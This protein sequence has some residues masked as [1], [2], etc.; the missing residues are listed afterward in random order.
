M[1]SEC[2]CRSCEMC[3]WVK[4][5][6][7]YIM[8]MHKEE[9]A[10]WVRK[11]VYKVYKPAT[12]KLNHAKWIC[13][14]VCHLFCPLIFVTQV[15]EAYA[16]SLNTSRHFHSSP[17]MFSTMEFDGVAL[18]VF[19]TSHTLHLCFGLHLLA[20]VSWSIFEFFLPPWTFHVHAHWTWLCTL[21]RQ[22]TRHL[23]NFPLL[24]PSC[25]NT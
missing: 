18:S 22:E 23:E 9:Y 12:Q 1:F 16:L 2:V 4:K 7:K 13:K 25:T 15:I 19:V 5:T 17:S 8:S 10:W 3:K 11:F 14:L 20:L 6:C 24:T 21:F